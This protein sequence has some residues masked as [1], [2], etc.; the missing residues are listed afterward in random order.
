VRRSEAEVDLK[1]RFPSLASTRFEVT[2]DD[3]RTYNCL[4][5]V[6]GDQENWI[7][8][9]LF[10]EDLGLYP[11]PEGVPRENTVR[12]WM[13][14]L[15]S[16][17]FTRCEEPVPEPGVEKVAVYWNGETQEIHF[18]L[19]LPSGLWTSKVGRW[20]D[21]THELDGLTGDRYGQVIGFVSRPAATGNER[22][23]EE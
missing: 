6:L 3:T 8:P 18:A 15:E 16:Y 14:A 11:W 23:A 1:R 21:I 19:Q 12:T 10:D 7:S 4:A 13:L 22:P 17:G 20:E 9:T 5:W 2:S